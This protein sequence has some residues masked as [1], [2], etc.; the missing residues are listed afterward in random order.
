MNNDEILTIK[1][2]A[3]YLKIAEKT[4]Y[5]FVCEGKLPGFRVGSA[6]RFKKQAIDEWININNNKT[7]AFKKINKSC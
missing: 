7:M 4:A 5:L 6:W 3:T 2:L 1:E